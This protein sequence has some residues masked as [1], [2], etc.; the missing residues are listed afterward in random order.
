MKRLAALAVLLAAAPAFAASPLVGKWKKDGA[1]YATVNADGTGFVHG[2]NARWK[3][4]GDVLTLAY[5]DGDVEVMK[6]RIDGDRLT[7]DMNGQKDSMTRMS[8]GASKAAAKTE[9]GGKTEKTG[10]AEA[11]GS[12]KLSRLLLSTAWCHFRYNQ[13]SGSSHQERVVF[14]ADGTWRKGARGESYSSGMY[15]TA[16]GQTDSTA[17]GRWKTKGSTWLTTTGASLL[18]SE[19][20]GPLQDAGLEISENSNG[21]PILKVGGKEY[22]SCD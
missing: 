12:D 5:D 21:Y 6:W 16:S 13:V 10:K 14:R 3:A 7:V 11:A 8:G 1:L 2:Q 19:G 20:N 17:G 4:D 18:L 22:S 15:G 9:K